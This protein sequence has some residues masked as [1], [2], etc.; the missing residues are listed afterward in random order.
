M[1]FSNYWN[2][3]VLRKTIA[4]YGLWGPIL[5]ILLFAL[6]TIAFV[7]G[8]M[9]TLAG[10]LIFGLIDGTLYNLLGSTLGITLSFIIA[11]Y[12]AHDWIM[13]KSS[14]KLNAMMESLAK[15]GWH[16]IAALRLIPMMPFNLMNY[17]V[18]FMPIRFGQYLLVSGL[19]ML[20][21]TVAYTYFGYL[22][23][24]AAARKNHLIAKTFIAL[25]LLTILAF[26]PLII[27]KIHHKLHHQCASSQ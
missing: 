15:E 9:M 1:N 6:N 14:K 4:E 7:P 5:F 11:R 22:G 12:L 8:T 20:P 16:Y 25:L 3:E 21:G 26:L 24:E 18:G 2:A 23:G 17:A 13:R 27:K 19:F 10:G